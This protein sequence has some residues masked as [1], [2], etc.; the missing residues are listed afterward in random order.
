[1]FVLSW[2]YSPLCKLFGSVDGFLPE[3]ITRA[4][5]LFGF[6]QGCFW[7]PEGENDSFHWSLIPKSSQEAEFVVATDA[8]K[9]GIAG[10]LLQEDFDGHLRPFAYWA[11]KKKDTVRLP[12]SAAIRWK[13]WGLLGYISLLRN[14]SGNEE[15]SLARW[16]NRFLDISLLRNCTG[17]GKTA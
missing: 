15:F 7:D 5:S 4:S 16:G 13:S 8:S 9:V 3:I 14:R 1:M 17:N 10:V 6:Y 12:L 2:M 11:Q